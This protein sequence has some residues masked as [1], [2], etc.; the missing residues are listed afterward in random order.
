M[1]RTFTQCFFL[2]K[3]KA[4]PTG[5]RFIY[6]RITVDGKRAEISTN[7]LVLTDKWNSEARKIKGTGDDIKKNNI[8]LLE[9]QSKI[10]D[11]Y[12][13]LIKEN[14]TITAEAIK[15]KFTGVSVFHRMLIPIF[16]KHNDEIES[17]VPHEF[18]IGTLE[19]YKTSLSHTKDFLK[20]KFKVSDI[21]ISEINHEFITDYDYY[22]R[23]VRKCAGH[24]INYSSEGCKQG[25]T[26]FAANVELKAL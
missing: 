12:Q 5:P 15:N 24:T 25:G 26:Q 20:W 21:D 4:D 19:R 13:A 3:S 8:H 14:K 17:L 18:A 6:I 9:L 1:I 7:T 16:Q 2:K 11:A 23:S 22:L 10:N